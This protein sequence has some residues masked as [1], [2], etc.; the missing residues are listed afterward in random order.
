ML[1]FEYN[2]LFIFKKKEHKKNSAFN[3][4]SQDVII[5]FNCVNKILKQIIFMKV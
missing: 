5:V 1:Q 2:T 3:A 4:E